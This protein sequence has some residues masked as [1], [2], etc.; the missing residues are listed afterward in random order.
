MNE[1]WIEIDGVFPLSHFIDLIV[2]MYYALFDRLLLNS[3]ILS[4]A[5]ED[6]MLAVDLLRVAYELGN[7]FVEQA[8]LQGILDDYPQDVAIWK[9]LITYPVSRITDELEDEEEQENENEN[10]NDNNNG[11]GRR[12]DE[13]LQKRKKTDF[14]ESLAMVLQLAEQAANTLSET[15]DL[16]TITVTVIQALTAAAKTMS[17]AGDV[18][19]LYTAV[20]QYYQN[21]VKATVVNGEVVAEMTRFFASRGQMQECVECIKTHKEMLLSAV[22]PFLTTMTMLIPVAN[23][24]EFLIEDVFEVKDVKSTMKPFRF[25][26]KLV[27]HLLHC[28]GCYK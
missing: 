17:V 23:R 20:E 7:V 22:E 18:S 6:R 3:Y 13:A 5:C 19:A 28:C 15:V 4:I 12:R 9:E 16:A 2:Y 8:V 25:R 11:E 10:D 21:A 1:K 24:A 26:I 27:K 14:A